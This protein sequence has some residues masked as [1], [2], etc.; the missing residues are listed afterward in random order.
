MN[1]EYC[2]LIINLHI[3][4]IEKQDI[5]LP[6]KRNYIN[7]LDKETYFYQ[8]EEEYFNANKENILKV[9]NQKKE[10]YG[11]IFEVLDICLN[12]L[13]IRKPEKNIQ[14][15]FQ[16]I[17]IREDEYKIE[18]VLMKK[19][20]QGNLFCIFQLD[21][22]RVKEEEY[23]SIFQEISPWM[24]EC[25]ELKIFHTLE[26]RHLLEDFKTKKKIFSNC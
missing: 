2:A 19:I 7:E 6:Y 3:Y 15:L 10:E 24:L 22:E 12:K 5:E 17:K 26:F 20:A 4:G 1:T 14:P 23:E 8:N 25:L 21:K 16:T 18:D 13:Y 9:L 11:L